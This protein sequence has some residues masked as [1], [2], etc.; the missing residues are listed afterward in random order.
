MSRLGQ[1]VKIRG[2]G[3][4]GLP[5]WVTYDPEW[6]ADSLIVGGIHETE[7]LAQQ[8]PD[9]SYTIDVHGFLGV[10]DGTTLPLPTGQMWLWIVPAVIA[11][12]FGGI[13]EVRATVGSV[14]IFDDSAG[15]YYTG[16]ISGY[17][18]NGMG[19][20][21]N[22]DGTPVTSTSPMTW[23]VADWLMFSIR[24]HVVPSG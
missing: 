10:G 5:D 3:G 13:Y 16:V 6:S 21:F 24:Y 8:N 22:A 7:Y 23:A 14:L 1:T 2:G 12:A 15:T 17:G 18:F 4:G 20:F 9:G 11:A 19:S